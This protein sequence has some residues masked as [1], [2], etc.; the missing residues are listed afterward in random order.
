MELLQ[1]ILNSDWVYVI[2]LAVLS[3]LIWIS[4]RY[5]TKVLDNQFD[6]IKQENKQGREEREYDNYLMLKGLQVMSDCEHELIY[7]VMHGTHNGGLERANQE[8][9]E[10][11]RLSNES[12]MKKAARWNL[13]IGR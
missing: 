13:K 6:R 3:F 7:C 2:G 8:L 12:L 9:E 11:R 10:Y 4:K 5:I 1:K